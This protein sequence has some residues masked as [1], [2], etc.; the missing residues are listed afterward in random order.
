MDIP[1]NCEK[2]DIGIG[3]VE[4]LAF[5]LVY[6]EGHK[7]ND[8]EGHSLNKLC[9]ENSRNNLR[10]RVKK[11]MAE[12]GTK[13]DAQKVLDKYLESYEFG[14]PGGGGGRTTDPIMA[15]ALDS[16]RKLIKKALAAKDIKMSTVSSA[17]LTAKAKLLVERR[18]ELLAEAKKAVAKR[19][20]DMDGILDD[21]A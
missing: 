5:P 20:K 3:G 11:V 12:G 2:T 16:A 17:D 18:P 7:C 15:E 21:V 9:K 14:K 8:N 19:E 6:A 13:E 1:A 10:E 4:G